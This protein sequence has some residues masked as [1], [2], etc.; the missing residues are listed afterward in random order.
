MTGEQRYLR[1]MELFFVMHGYRDELMYIQ[2]TDYA[3]LEAFMKLLKA[4]Y[5]AGEDSG[6]V[7]ALVLHALTFYK[8][9]RGRTI[10]WL[11]RTTEDFNQTHRQRDTSAIT[12]VS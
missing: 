2:A 12:G 7:A 9:D 3:Y 11:T 4:G 10:S 6:V 1:E 5:A 8:Q